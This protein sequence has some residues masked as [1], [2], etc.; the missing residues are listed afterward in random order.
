M[1]RENLI[2][3]VI[4]CIDEA[5]LVQDVIDLVNIESPTGSEG[6]MGDF[7]AVRYADL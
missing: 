2:T 4:S 5:R 7:M 3:N 1:S 6:A